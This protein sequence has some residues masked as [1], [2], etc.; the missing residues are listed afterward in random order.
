[1]GC[2]SSVIQKM[3][4]TYWEHTVLRYSGGTRFIPWLLKP[5]LMLPGHQQ[6]QYCMINKS[7]S[8]IRKD[9]MLLLH[10]SV[11][12]WFTDYACICPN[13]KQEKILFSW[14]YLSW[15][16]QTTWH[17]YFCRRLFI[18]LYT[19]YMYHIHCV[20]SVSFNILLS[21]TLV[22]AI[23]SST[24]DQS[25]DFAGASTNLVQFSVPQEASGGVVINVAI[26]TCG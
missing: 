9:F 13:N 16:N 12:K 10:C 3:T 6:P 21:L 23:E 18:I 11:E 17:Y 2:L 22:F 14:V 4:A 25:T 20:K 5:W 7:F 15:T 1:M 19:R 24:N 8:S 26:T